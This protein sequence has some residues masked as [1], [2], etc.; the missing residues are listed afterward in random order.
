[1]YTLPKMTSRVRDYSQIPVRIRNLFSIAATNAWVPNAGVQFTSVLPETTFGT[2]YTAITDID[3]NTLMRDMGK[4]LT[5]LDASGRHYATLRR[6]QTV[7][8]PTTEGVPDN[9]NTTGQYYV[10]VWTADPLSAYNP[11]VVRSG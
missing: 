2:Q 11:T 7:N 10:S 6:V 4:T 8:G 9:W 5:L 1:M 3:A